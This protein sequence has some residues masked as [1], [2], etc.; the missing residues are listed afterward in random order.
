MKARRREREMRGG[1]SMNYKTESGSQN[2]KRRET[3]A[4]GTR[5]YE[6]DIKRAIK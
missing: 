4:S 1:S 6:R 5:V 2:K 3:E